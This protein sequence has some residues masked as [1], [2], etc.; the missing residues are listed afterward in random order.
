M[1]GVFG[2]GMKFEIDIRGFEETRLLL[3]KLPLQIERRIVD[4][5]AKMAMKPM[6]ETAR[7][8]VVANG[9]DRT[10]QLRESLSLRSRKL[11][12]G[13]RSTRMGPNLKRYATRKNSSGKAVKYRPASIAH[14]VERGTAAHKIESKTGKKLR[15]RGGGFVNGG[16]MHPGTRARPFMEPAF[17]LHKR[18]A[19]RVYGQ[20]LFKR[21]ERWIAR[22]RHV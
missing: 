15:L 21:A 4:G 20:E 10:G 11:R 14:L 19:L 22:N 5:A 13:T 3:K 17:E 7:S 6:L 9:S 2:Y 1:S 18:R 12:D 16:V 8:F